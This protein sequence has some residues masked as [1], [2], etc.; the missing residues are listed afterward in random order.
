MNRSARPSCLSQFRGT[1]IAMGDSN[2]ET[3]D[4]P[5]ELTCVMC[6]D[7]Y[8]YPVI[9]LCR[10]TFCKGCISKVIENHGTCPLC[11]GPLPSN[12]DELLPSLELQSRCDALPMTCNYSVFG[13]TWKGTRS[14]YFSLHNDICT[15]AQRL[16]E[17]GYYLLY[18][19]DDGDRILSSDMI[20]EY[21][22]GNMYHVYGPTTSYDGT[23]VL[24][25]RRGVVDWVDTISNTPGRTLITIND[26]KSMHGEAKGIGENNRYNIIT[27]W[28]FHGVR[29]VSGLDDEVEILRLLMKLERED[30]HGAER[31]IMEMLNKRLEEL[32]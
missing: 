23:L 14:E 5:I 3:N 16:L 11:R 19:V 10:H 20:V 8:Q 27:D 22:T 1:R 32:E 26:D 12:V 15:F 6:I 13:C 2:I 31:N 18:R 21:P 29:V 30:T 17:P 4:I 28:S 7:A 24:N 9:T 25:G